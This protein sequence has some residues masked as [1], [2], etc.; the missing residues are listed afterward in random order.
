MNLNRANLAK[1]AQLSGSTKSSAP[2]K[3]RIVHIGLGAFSRA[4]Q[5]W[6]TSQVDEAGEWGIVAFTGRSAEVA[7]QLAPQDGLFTLVTRG[8]QGDSFE[9]IDAV[10]RVCNGSDWDSFSAAITN[11]DTAIVTLTITEAGYRVLPNGHLDTSDP[12]VAADLLSLE[13]R[14]PTQLHSALARLAFGINQRR[15]AGGRG[16][17]LVSCDN[18][19][20]NATVLRQAMTDWFSMFGTVA[21]HW[22]EANVT[23]V[24]TSVDRITPK[25]TAAEI[26]EVEANTGWK[27]ASPVVTE[28]FSSW[29]LEGDFPLGRPAWENAG[30]QF[31]SNIE[32]FENRKLWLLNGAHSL[33]AYAGQLLGH[34]TVAEAIDDSR[35]LGWV[36]DFWDE[37]QNSL[38]QKEL[39]VTE[40]RAALI[41]RFQ[42]ARIEHRLEQIAAD[43]ATKLRVRVAPVALTELAMGRTVTG[44]ATVFA[45]WIGFVLREWQ[46]GFAN[47]KDTQAATLISVLQASDSNQLGDSTQEGQVRSLINLVEPRLAASDSF[48]DQVLTQLEMVG[49]FTHKI[50][51]GSPL[52]V[53]N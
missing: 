25:T 37:A 7:N 44:C 17:A 8:P 6:Y 38:T 14:Q 42:N 11:P 26:L 45:A 39:S 12:L 47:F 23:F 22:L 5:A 36:T 1:S 33:L 48:T 43:G 27:D 30:A 15:L 10:T 50:Q 35:C 18:L 51:N 29:I 24:S 40:Y 4:H 20:A 21:V 34:A 3:E 31:V 53:A 9:V 32:H 46:T 19:P 28:P 2:S 13:D 16:L 41:A 52:P 49:Q